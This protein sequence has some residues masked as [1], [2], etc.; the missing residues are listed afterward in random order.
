M[1]ETAPTEATGNILEGSR[2]AK[3]E[4]LVKNLRIGKS[5]GQYAEA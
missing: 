2:E 3:M 4:I 1:T 5:H